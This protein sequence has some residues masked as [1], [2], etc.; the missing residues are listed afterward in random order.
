M[1]DP[2]IAKFII[3]SLLFIIYIKRKLSKICNFYALNKFAEEENYYR[4]ISKVK[5]DT[6]VVYFRDAAIKDNLLSY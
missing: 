3:T 1:I 4:R 2:L 6:F 5:K